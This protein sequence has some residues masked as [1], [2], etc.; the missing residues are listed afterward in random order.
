MI[1][2][3]NFSNNTNNNQ[4]TLKTLTTPK[5]LNVTTNNQGE[6]WLIIGVDSG[7]EATTTI[8]F[9]RVKIKLER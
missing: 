5:T 9:N 4:Y 2:L 1:V 7:F 6:L 8:Y 3:G